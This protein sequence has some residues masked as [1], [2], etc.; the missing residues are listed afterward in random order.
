MSKYKLHC[1]SRHERN[2]QNVSRV[3]KRRSK[4]VAHVMKAALSICLIFAVKAIN[5]YDKFI[6]S[7]W[8]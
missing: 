4:L 3:A 8:G 5:L 1:S 6:D 2:I 7:L